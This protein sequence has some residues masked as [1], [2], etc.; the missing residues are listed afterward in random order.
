MMRSVTV[1]VW[2]MCLLV[3]SVACIPAESVTRTPEVLTPASRTAVAAATGKASGRTLQ[4]LILL[5]PLCAKCREVYHELDRAGF[6]QGWMAESMFIGVLGE[7]QGEWNNL[8]VEMFA[9]APASDRVTTLRE[10]MGTVR[11]MLSGRAGEGAACNRDAVDEMERQASSAL[12]A[13][14]LTPADLPVV[15]IDSLL[16]ARGTSPDDLASLLSVQ[17]SQ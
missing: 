15:V 12:E 6:F 7:D 17:V 14:G 11:W 4:R 3:G 13:L 1:R 5:Q 2:V 16:F 9:C 8:G 10:L